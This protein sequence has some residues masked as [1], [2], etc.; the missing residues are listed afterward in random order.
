MC[1]LHEEEIENLRKNIESLSLPSNYNIEQDNKKNNNNNYNNK[2]I[3]FIMTKYN[4]KIILD[5]DDEEEEEEEEE[6]YVDSK[7][8]LNNNTNEIKLEE[9]IDE[10]PKK[11]KMKIEKNFD[12]I[13]DNIYQKDFKYFYEQRAKKFKEVNFD[14]F[15]YKAKYT[16]KKKKS[17]SDFNDIFE[18]IGNNNH[19]SKY[20]AA[21]EDEFVSSDSYDADLVNLTAKVNKKFKLNTNLSFMEN[22]KNL[23]EIYKV[24]KICKER[25]DKN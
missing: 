17:K 1:D 6:N 4:K 8:N 13:Y 9:K 16:P 7:I 2:K 3:E 24:L 19:K 5:D 23:N 22:K 15:S 12:D 14:S 25:D 21:N 18:E 11:Q 10:L 20:E